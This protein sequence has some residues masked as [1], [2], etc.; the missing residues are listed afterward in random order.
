M[1]ILGHALWLFILSTEV[2]CAAVC[3]GIFACFITTQP[4][5]AVLPTVAALVMHAPLLLLGDM[6]RDF[7]HYILSGSF[8]LPWE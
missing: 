3:I 4:V 5:V 8:A 1:R 7:V 6:R 2:A